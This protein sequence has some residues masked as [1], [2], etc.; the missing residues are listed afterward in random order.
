MPMN[1][2]G[3][4]TCIAYINGNRNTFAQAQNWPWNLPVIGRGFNH[5]TRAEF[6]AGRLNLQCVIRLLLRCCLGKSRSQ[7]AP[8][9]DGCDNTAAHGHQCAA[10]KPPP[11]KPA[12]WNHRYSEDQTAIRPKRLLHREKEAEK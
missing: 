4:G 3:V 12:C 7:D 5:N 1:E 11:L 2:V 6:Y 9:E 10:H 8:R